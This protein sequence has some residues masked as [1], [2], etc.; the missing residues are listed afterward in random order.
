MGSNKH[1]VGTDRRS[2]PFQSGSYVPVVSI[3]RGCLKVHRFSRVVVDIGEGFVDG[4]ERSEYREQPRR[5]HRLN[6]QSIAFLADHCFLTWQLEVAR[7]ADGL[8][9]SVGEESRSAGCVHR[10][11][12]WWP[13][14]LHWLA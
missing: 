4:L 14:R 13:M 8:I 10:Q 12:C 5:R 6:D 7:D 3:G 11:G 9:S 2:R 1:V